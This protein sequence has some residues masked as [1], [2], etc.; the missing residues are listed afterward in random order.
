[1]KWV[2][3]ELSYTQAGTKCRTEHQVHQHLSPLGP[4]LLFHAIETLLKGLIV[5][6][7][8]KDL[9]KSSSPTSL[10][11]D[12]KIYPPNSSLDFEMLFTN[13]VLHQLTCVRMFYIFLGWSIV[14]K[15]VIILCHLSTYTPPPPPWVPKL[16]NLSWDLLNFKISTQYS[17]FLF[18]FAD[19]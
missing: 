14:L 7:Y 8:K 12:W 18:K 3:Q 17:F 11:K 9:I 19:F 1:M 16:S 6:S 13:F 2:S 15:W 4:H 5:M 10:F